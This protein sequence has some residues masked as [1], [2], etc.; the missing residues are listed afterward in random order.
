MTQQDL[1]NSLKALNLPL[2]Y[3]HFEVDD[4]NPPPTLPFICYKFT[5]NDGDLFADNTNYFQISSF[6]IEL[7]TEFKDLGAE[8]LLEDKL[9][10]LKLPFGKSEVYIKEE[11]MF[12]ILYS[13]EI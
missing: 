10:E 9:K 7:Y 12:Q 13:I 4:K 8:K 11:R 3:D 2:A 1:F 6:N 5:G